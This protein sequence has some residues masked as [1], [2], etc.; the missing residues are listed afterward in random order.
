MHDPGRMLADGVGIDDDAE[1]YHAW[2]AKTLSAFQTVEQYRPNRYVKY[3][4]GKI[5]ARGLW[6]RGG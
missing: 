3:R 4:I 1:Q 6:Y 2:Y 5:Y